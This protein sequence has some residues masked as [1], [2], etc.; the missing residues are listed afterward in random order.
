[1]GLIR[2]IKPSAGTGEGGGPEGRAVKSIKRPRSKGEAAYNH[3]KELKTVNALPKGA[4]KEKKKKT[5]VQNLWES[6]LMA[7]IHLADRE[8]FFNR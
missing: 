8:S 5:I 1:M 7:E 4:E 3:A 2:E 6:D